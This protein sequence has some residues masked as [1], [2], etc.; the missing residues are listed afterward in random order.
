MASNPGI[1][2]S[3][4]SIKDCQMLDWHSANGKPKETA[5]R[6]ALKKLNNLGHISL[7]KA[8]A[9]PPGRKTLPASAATQQSNSVPIEGALKELGEIEIIKIKSRYTVLSGKWNELMDRYHYLASGPLCGQQLKYI[10]KSEHYGYIGGFAFSS[11]SLKL[12]A[13]DNWIG[14]DCARRK[15]HLNK[16][17]TNIRFLILPHIRVSN[18]ASHVMGKCIGQMREDWYE[19]YKIYPVL[20]ET[21]VERSKYDGTSYRASNWLYAGKTRGRG[22]NGSSKKF[23]KSVKDIY[24][25]PLEK[26]ARL[27]LSGRESKLAVVENRDWAENEFGR[28]KIDD[29]RLQ[30]RLLSLGRDFYAQPQ[31][32][33]PQACGTRAKA[34]AAYRF[35]DNAKV[36][37]DKILASHYEAA[38]LRIPK[39]KIVLSVQDTTTLNYTAHPGTE[40]IGPIGTM[41][42]GAMGLLVHDTMA[43][44]TE[45][46]PLGLIN[47]QSW[48]RDVNEFGKKGDYRRL[49]IEQKESNK[50][51]KSF[52]AS[53][54]IQDKCKDTTIV[55]V[56]DREADFYELFNL[57][58]SEESNPKLLI[59][60]TK[61]R[62]LVR[63]QKKLKEYITSRSV[64]GK[65]EVKIPRQGKQK[66]REAQLEIRFSAVTLKPPMHL[67]EMDS[68]SVYAIHAREIKTSKGITPIEWLLLTTIQVD[69]LEEAIEKLNWYSK[70][71]G[72]ETY[73]RTLKSG[74]KIEERQLG[75]AERIET[76]LAIDM[77]V[78]WRVY[79]L[80]KLGR[81]VPDLPCSVFFEEAE[82]KALVAYKTENPIPP[83]NPPTLKEAMNMT[84]SLGGFLGR[85]CDGNPG[86]KSLWLGLQRLDDI[87]ATWKVMMKMIN[88]ARGS[89]PVVS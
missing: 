28:A 31:A 4:L 58:V 12:E 39:E 74:C 87:T 64:A 67:K 50:W 65:L 86:T 71:W 63:E 2:R 70:R 79:H 46:T 9:A 24:L 41:P 43:F 73:H 76:C 45:G 15:E 13:R 60:A 66:A 68:L 19:R 54:A 17:V 8:R 78:A 88:A 69:T 22:R 52:R 1:S 53:K 27:L 89:P 6:L 30:E 16:V 75:N 59:R 44:N 11:A 56:G 49:P 47:V 42:D 57:A 81:E 72:I 3:Q 26:K 34:K 29:A 7:P 38:L 25:Y 82:W 55:S 14:W 48:A 83:E 33:I 10:I 62:L 37:M 40:N 35:L 32:N 51:L 18:L 23:Q 77:V 80:T 20:L 21:F 61:N 85:K 5:C 36:T 84:A